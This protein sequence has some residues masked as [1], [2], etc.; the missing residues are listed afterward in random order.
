MA[1]RHYALITDVCHRTCSVSAQGVP[2]APP[3]LQMYYPTKCKDGGSGGGGGGYLMDLRP[4]GGGCF[5][6]WNTPF[7]LDLPPPS[8][9]G[10]R[11]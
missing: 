5:P 9:G 6:Q 1:T 10:E 11:G 8:G 4:P 3:S 2:H 7:I